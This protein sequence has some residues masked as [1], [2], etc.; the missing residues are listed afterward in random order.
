M[1][2]FIFDEFIIQRTK[3]NFHISQIH[4]TLKKRAFLR[5]L[6]TSDN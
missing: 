1:A 2:L 3:F 6:L 4:K 5:V